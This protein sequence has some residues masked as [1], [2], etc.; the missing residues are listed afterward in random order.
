[1]TPDLSQPWTNIQAGL[2]GYGVAKTVTL[3][4]A[5]SSGRGFYRTV[6]QPKPTQLL[7][8]Q[9]MAFS[10]IGYDCGGIQEKVYLTGFDP[11]NG[12][13]T[14]N[15]DLKTI[16][17]CGKD[18]SSTHTASAAV[19]WDFAGNAI[20]ASAPATGAPA[21]PAFIATDGSNDIVYNSGASAYIIVP[22]P[23]APM[24]V[25]AV[26]SNDQFQVSWT[27]NGVNPIAITSSTLTA[28]PIDNSSASN[29]TTLVSGPV[30]N[31]IIPSLQPSTTYQI[32]V[33]STTLGGSGP[34]S[35]PISVGTSAATILP[36]APPGL[37]AQ[38]AAP[39]ADPGPNN[40]IAAWQ[41]ADPG[42]SPV[43]QYLVTAVGSDGAGSL[44][45]SVSGTTLTTS[46][47]VDSTYNWS[48]KVQAHN[49]AGW[50]PVSAQF[51][52]G[53]L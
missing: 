20:L 48:V 2:Q 17:S 6:I 36:S 51:T 53:G 10:I 24:G 44:T 13:P 21:N 42:N 28:T 18:C 5:L 37:S 19:T 4:N 35:V 8:S 12:Y 25:T 34:A 32:T 26:Q 30:T 14:G 16:C 27:P 46:F 11:T 31:G 38:W 33:V 29:L 1:M 47:N 41:A 52:L 15:V 23:A 50:G 49:A 7:L 22:V 45:N 3:S 43:D 39:N 9:S 40:I